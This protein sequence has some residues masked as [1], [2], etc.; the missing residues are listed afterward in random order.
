[1]CIT[2][3]LTKIISGLLLCPYLFFSFPHCSI[4]EGTIFSKNVII[5][6]LFFFTFF[7]YNSDFSML[8]PT[9]IVWYETPLE[10]V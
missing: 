4:I 1:L 8:R 9:N 10:Q 3:G 5:A 7:H 2:N 6:P